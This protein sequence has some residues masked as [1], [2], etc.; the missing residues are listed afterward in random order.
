MSLQAISEY[1][2]FK[3]VNELPEEDFG[4]DFKIKSGDYEY[5]YSLNDLN[6]DVLHVH[7]VNANRTLCSLY[8]VLK[9][10]PCELEN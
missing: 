3:A 9:I 5:A 7:E 1:A 10:M 6:K 8:E 4:I 2:T